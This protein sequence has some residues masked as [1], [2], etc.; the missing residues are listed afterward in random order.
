MKIVFSA[1]IGVIVDFAL[2]KINIQNFLKNVMISV[3]DVM[4]YE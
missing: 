2:S 4:K 1:I 3:N